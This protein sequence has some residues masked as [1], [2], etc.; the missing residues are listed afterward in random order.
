MEICG[1]SGVRE[2]DQACLWLSQ[3]GGGIDVEG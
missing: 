3:L 2:Q 1:A